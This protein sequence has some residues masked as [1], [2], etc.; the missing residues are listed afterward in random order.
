MKVLIIGHKSPYP[1]IDGGCF[2]MA[3]FLENVLQVPNIEVHY[4][5]L[6]TFK[7]PFKQENF[8]QI[9]QTNFH[10]SSSPIQTELKVIP[11]FTQLIQGKNYNLSRFYDKKTAQQ[12][13]LI[14]KEFKPNFVIFESLFSAVYVD[15][16]SDIKKWLRAH[17]VEHEIWNNLH[18]STKRSPKKWYIKQLY[19][20]LHREEIILWKKLDGIFTI[21]EDDAK[22]IAKHVDIPLIFVP[23]A[24]KKQVVKTDFSSSD[25]CFLG[26]YNWEPNKEAIEWFLYKIFPEILKKS[27]STLLHL[28]GIESELLKIPE[29]VRHSVRVHGFV[30]SVSEFFMKHGIFV[31]P[32]LSGSGVKIKVLEAM[33]HGIPCVLT[34]KAAEG[35]GL[36]LPIAV[37]N[38]E[39]AFIEEVLRL[40]QDED[41]RKI[42]GNKLQ[43][44]AQ[45]NFGEES[46]VGILKDKISFSP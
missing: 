32:M 40:I 45:T 9:K 14:Q 42:L 46:V 13:K 25:L 37:Q 43:N 35:L 27:P 12:L 28:A 18:Q 10:I 21:S 1:I 34:P 6:S 44:F 38:T 16:F 41:S 36:N 7:H 19:Q 2:A 20:S 30:E 23:V 17:N 3:R 29:Q 15:L 4:F 24:L 11:A 22:I 39:N 5:V 33:N 31:A 8:P 26:A